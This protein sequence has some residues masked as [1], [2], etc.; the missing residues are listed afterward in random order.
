MEF[1]EE[2]CEDNVAGRD[3][4]EVN[5]LVGFAWGGTGRGGERN[6]RMSGLWEQGGM[7][8]YSWE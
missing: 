5:V 6:K 3:G 2:G 4:G 1:L 7:N 8:N